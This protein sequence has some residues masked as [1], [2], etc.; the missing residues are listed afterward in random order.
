LLY[1]HSKDSFNVTVFEQSERIGGLWPLTAPDDGMVNPDMCTN[2]SRHTVSF[3]DMAWPES[4]PTFPKAW[5]VGQ[6]LKR[7]VEKH[8]RIGIQTSCKVLKAARLADEA[9]QDGKR[10]K[11]E[12][13]KT[14]ILR[15]HAESTVDLK[16]ASDNAVTSGLLQNKSDDD[17]PELPPETLY[18]DYLIVA[19]GFFGKPKFPPGLSNL[20]SS[21]TPVQ[22]ST[23][24][25]S[26]QDLLKGNEHTAGSHGKKIL[27]VGGSM[28]GAEIAA[29]IAMQLSSEQNSPGE[30]RLQDA[31]KYT[32]HHVVRRPFWAM[33]L[34][35]P[36][37]PV[38]PSNGD[39]PKVCKDSQFRF[40]VVLAT[41]HS[42]KYC[43]ICYICLW[44]LN[45][46]NAQW[47]KL[48]FYRHTIPHQPFY[49][50]T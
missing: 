32:V 27:V 46:L 49:L 33:P 44:T 17:S 47:S 28:S 6:Y 7:Y 38:V 1:N 45:L 8:N 48:T 9:L 13:Q 25:R 16:I 21:K 20:D 24:F 43:W 30:Q 36:V 39:D 4:S 11:V 37:D 34:F 31:S 29:S 12:I 23:R 18:F 14:S 3:S 50:S 26:A 2:L 5:Q 10:W 19:S 15:P 42:G 40:K 35:L 22:H 41:M